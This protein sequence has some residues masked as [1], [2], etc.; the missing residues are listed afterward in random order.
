MFAINLLDLLIRHSCANQKRETI[1]FS[2]SVPSAIARMWVFLTWR[3]YCKWFSERR[4]DG[5]PAMRAGVCT[6]R[7]SVSRLLKDRLFPGRVPLPEAWAEHYWGRVPTRRI[8]RPQRHT[9][10]YAA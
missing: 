1:A 10:S 3:N 7:W 5:T 9:L 4:R 8:A 6:Q 2:K